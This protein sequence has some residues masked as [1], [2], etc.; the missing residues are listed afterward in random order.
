M[1]AAKKTLEEALKRY[2]DLEKGVQKATT[3]KK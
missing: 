1:A 3:P 2:K